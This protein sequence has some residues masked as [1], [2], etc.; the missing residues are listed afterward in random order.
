MGETRVRFLARAPS[1]IARGQMGARWEAI[2]DGLIVAYLLAHGV[3]AM[4]IDCQS[5]LPDVSPELYAL[6]DAVG[7]TA[8]VQRWGREQ[9]DFLVLE[10]PVWFKAFIFCE[11]RSRCGRVVDTRAVS[12]RAMCA[13][14]QGVRRRAAHRHH[15]PRLSL[16]LPCRTGGLSGAE[17]LCDRGGVGAAAGGC[18]ASRPLL[19]GARPQLDGSHH[20]CARTARGRNADA[21]SHAPRVL[22]GVRSQAVLRAW[23]RLFHCTLVD[24]RG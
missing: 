9:G 5:I 10:N 1:G 22:G 24:S 23:R 15:A 2:A 16:A 6:Y 12:A 20:G 18:A 7:L 19:R 13:M 11:V 4:L 21:R 8:V 17:L 3:I 14:E